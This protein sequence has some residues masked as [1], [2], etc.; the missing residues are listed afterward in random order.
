MPKTALKKKCLLI[1]LPSAKRASREKK[2]HDA[3]NVTLRN[4]SASFVYV[5][6]S[7]FRGD[8]PREEVLA[9]LCQR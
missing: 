1:I 3:G 2:I 9:T 4:S 8:R 7:S 6:T 5:G